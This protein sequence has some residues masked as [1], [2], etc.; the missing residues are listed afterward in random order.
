[1]IFT[2]ISS[3]NSL[4]QLNHWV[5]NHG[6]YI[7]EYVPDSDSFSNNW[8]G[9]EHHYI[10]IQMHRKAHFCINSLRP[11]EVFKDFIQKW[12]LNSDLQNNIICLSFSVL[13][14][15]WFMGLLWMRGFMSVIRSYMAC[16]HDVPNHSTVFQQFV[17]YQ[18]SA[19]HTLCEEHA[20]VIWRFP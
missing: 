3:V 8:C 18:R 11:S 12:I 20:A 2:F 13:I 10:I 15:N 9:N 17:Q 5:F 14:Q 4:N 16:G 1:M 6:N 19:L 7:N